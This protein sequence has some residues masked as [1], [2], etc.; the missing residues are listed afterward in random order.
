MTAAFPRR[1][2]KLDHADASRPGLA[3]QR[4]RAVPAPVAA[5]RDRKVRDA[6]LAEQVR[7]ARR[8]DRLLVGRGEHDLDGK[9]RRGLGR[10][11]AARPTPPGRG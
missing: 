5:D 7:D 10:V 3:R 4:R 9:R 1:V 2:A 11:A 8:D 6:R